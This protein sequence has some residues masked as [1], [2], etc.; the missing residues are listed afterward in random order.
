M[1]EARSRLEWQQTSWILAALHNGLLRG[2]GDPARKPADFDP[3]EQADRGPPL[4]LPVT[5]LR[6][7]VGG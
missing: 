5:A 7:L 3:H 1:A 6:G 2:R 4:K